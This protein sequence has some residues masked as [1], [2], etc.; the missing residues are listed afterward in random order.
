VNILALDTTLGA[1]SAAV[2]RGG[3]A[4]PEK[5]SAFELRTREHAEVIVPMMT[6]VMDE[7]GLTYDGLDAIAVTTGPG[8]FT[9]VRVGV[10]TARGLALALGLPLIG[11]T[12]LEVMA[13]MALEQLDSA[14]DTL[15]IVVD[16]RRGEV[17]MALFDGEGAVISDPSARTPEQAVELIPGKGRVVLAG[18]G[19]GLVSGAA[20]SLGLEFDTV[21]PVLQPDAA[22]LASLALTR[23]ACEGPLHPLYLRPPDAKPQT[24]KAIPRRG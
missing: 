12:S 7:A 16:A 18:G 8:T 21:L 15:G 23:T 20:K 22:T 6:R 24:G 1:C 19:A 14:P 13:H 10:S 9:G 17:Y 11:V 2:A 3:V 4:A 5:F